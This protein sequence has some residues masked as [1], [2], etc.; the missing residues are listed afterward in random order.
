MT[1]RCQ[2]CKV[3]F[4]DHYKSELKETHTCTNCGYHDV[5]FFDMDQAPE[6]YYPDSEDYEPCEHDWQELESIDCSFCRLCG[7]YDC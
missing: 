3:G 2:F 6:P 7:A 1:E 4:L 5:L